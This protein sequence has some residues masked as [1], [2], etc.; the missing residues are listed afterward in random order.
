MKKIL[1]CLF[2]LISMAGFAKDNPAFFAEDFA[3]Q[4][5]IWVQ[6]DKISQKCQAV[7]I[8][9]T[10]YL[11]AAHCVSPICNKH[12]SISVQLLSG[13][14]EVSALVE[15]KTG[16]PQVFVP[17]SYHGEELRSI[18]SDIALIHFDPSEDEYIFVDVPHKE[19][20]D[21]ATFIKLLNQ[22]KYAFQ[23]GQWQELQ[24]ARPKLLMI[25]HS[26]NRKLTFP[27]AVPDLRSGELYFKQSPG[28]DFYYFTQLHHYIGPNFGVE[29]GM[30]GAGVVIPGGTVVGIVSAS[31]NHNGHIVVY[32]ENDEAR[33]TTAF[34]SNYFLFTPISRENAA[35]IQATIASFP[36]HSGTPRISTING[37][38]AQPTTKKLEDVFAE[39]SP[40]K[41]IQPDEEE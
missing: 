41:D 34:S 37:H 22:S 16:S 12:C 1:I 36:K 15:H 14:L 29:K 6:G 4:S 17:A 7:R 18:R 23:R 35:F 39:F 8:L 2:C 25:P 33:E 21:Q 20:V 28:A 5:V 11:T 31:F 40:A 10:W 3:N 13:D 27:L 30:S 9:P 26:I 24:Q 38:Y 19:Q 32:D